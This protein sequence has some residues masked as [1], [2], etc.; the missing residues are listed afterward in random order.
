MLGGFVEKTWGLYE[1]WGLGFGDE[2]FWDLDLGTRV[3]GFTIQ[4]I[5]G[6]RVTSRA[7]LRV[8]LR[9]WATLS[10]K[11]CSS[12]L[13]FKGSFQGSFTGSVRD[14]KHSFRGAL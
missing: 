14:S 7:L 4:G 5:A 9:L 3:W 12:G 10:E 13:Y 6:S 11:E 2:G 1:G 8:P